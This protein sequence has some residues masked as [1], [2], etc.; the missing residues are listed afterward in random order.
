VEKV[1]LFSL[2]EPQLATGGEKSL[3]ST[4]LKLTQQSLLWKLEGLT[5]E[6]LRRPTGKTGTNLIGIVKHLTGV[7]AEYLCSAF[8][9]ERESYPWESDEEL[10]FGLDMWATPEESPQEIIAMYERA[11]DA[12]AA[13]IEA[14]DLDTTGKHHTGLTVSLRWMILNVLS[15]TL[16][17][18]GHADVVRELIDGRVGTNEEYSNTIDDPEYWRM[19]HARMSGEIGRDEFVAFARGRS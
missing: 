9:R 2:Y 4:Y 13:S 18:C 7:T 16:R 1:H 15:D 6:E 17:H 10:F 11:C 12:A 5:D 14:L 8:G 19:Y 3:L